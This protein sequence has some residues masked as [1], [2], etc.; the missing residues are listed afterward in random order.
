MEVCECSDGFAYKKNIKAKDFVLKNKN[1][2][3]Q[4]KIIID[5]LKKEKLI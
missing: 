1:E 5:M 4:T 3:A 2:I